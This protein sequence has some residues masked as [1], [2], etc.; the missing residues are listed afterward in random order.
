VYKDRVNMGARQ[1]APEP[2]EAKPVESDADSKHPDNIKAE[3]EGWNSL[4]EKPRGCTDCLCLVSTYA[5]KFLG[6][7]LLNY[8]VST[9]S[10]YY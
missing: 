8:L 3:H 4:S 7:P 6:H 1:S 5:H 2:V 10:S 9:N